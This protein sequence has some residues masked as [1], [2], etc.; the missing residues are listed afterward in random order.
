MSVAMSS[1][2]YAHSD[3][4]NMSTSKETPDPTENSTF[5]EEGTVGKS[6]GWQAKL[7]YLK[8]MF[9]TKAGWLGDYVSLVRPVGTHWIC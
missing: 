1:A 2:E 5:P 4:K 9:T 3:E 6:H 8:W 7:A